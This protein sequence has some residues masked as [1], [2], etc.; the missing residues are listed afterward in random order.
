[1]KKV[2]VAIVLMASIA[3]IGCAK[4]GNKV[5]VTKTPN[6]KTITTV[7]SPQ[8]RVVSVTTK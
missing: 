5:S 4:Q 7:T 2:F 1:M 3:L 8:G 6:G